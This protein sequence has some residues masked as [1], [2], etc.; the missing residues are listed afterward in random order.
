MRAL[1][2]ISEGTGYNKITLMVIRFPNE[3]G[4]YR[5]NGRNKNTIAQRFVTT[6]ISKLLPIDAM[7][8]AHRYCRFLLV[9]TIN[10][11]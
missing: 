7:V 11:S 1:R 8:D 4:E 6:R 5:P 3:A 10:L 9:E 2:S